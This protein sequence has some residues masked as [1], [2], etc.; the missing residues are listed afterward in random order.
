LQKRVRVLRIVTRLGVSG[1][2]WQCIFLTE[3]LNSYGFESMLVCGVEEQ[4]EGNMFDLAHKIGINPL[5]IPQLRR[6][7][8]IFRDLMVVIKL[9]LLMK[10]YKPHI[11]HTHT[12]KAGTLGRISAWLAGVPVI[13]FT[14][15]GSYFQGYFSRVKTNVLIHIERILAMITDRIIAV[16][17]QERSDILQN[18]IGNE[19]KVI[20]I[21]LGLELDDLL[22]CE[23]F[24]GT[25][26]NELG[27]D[28]NKK[29]IGI[30]ARLVPIKGHRFF[31]ESAK[32]VLQSHSNVLFLV[33]GDGEL[34]KELK[35]YAESLGISDKV[36]FLGFRKDLPV[37]YAD[38]DIVALSSLSEGLPVTIIEGMA[39]AKPIVAARVGGVPELLDEGNA[40][41]I[42][43]AANPQELARGI[44]KILDN[45]DIAKKM[46]E[47]GRQTAMSR[48]RV[49]TLVENI[50]KLYEQLLEEKGLIQ[51][52]E[53]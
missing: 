12:S 14:L 23:R 1:P 25:L 18:K 2:S 42:V 22:T 37:I 21:P 36:M 38:L 4:Y 10:K 15:H 26:R 44:I 47:Y 20:N 13:I 45:P 8:F 34:Q 27:I 11:V 7:I 6:E 5:V 43:P 29:L 30:I 24:R 19:S 53:C 41:I 16:S 39:S 17:Q 50:A 9:Y 49:D 46:G 52:S 40:G 35:E 51:K 48:Y 3:R 32:L 33:I 31:L 28:S